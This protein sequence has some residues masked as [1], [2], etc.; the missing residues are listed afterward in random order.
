MPNILR[1][2]REI[3]SDIKAFLTGSNF[4]MSDLGLLLL[5]NSNLSSSLNNL[6]ID[7]FLQKPFSI[8]KN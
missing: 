2:V 3:N 5:P 7:E 8:E 1:K 4:G 6:I